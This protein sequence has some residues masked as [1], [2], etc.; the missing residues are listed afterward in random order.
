MPSRLQPVL[1]HALHLCAP[2]PQ[3]DRRGSPYACAAHAVRRRI[4]A[5]RDRRGTAYSQCCLGPLLTMTCS[6]QP[7]IENHVGRFASRSSSSF[8]QSRMSSIMPRATCLMSCS[9]AST[10]CKSTCRGTEALV[11]AHRSPSTGNLFGFSCSYESTCDTRA[12]PSS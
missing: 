3:G 11:R 8:S 12:S 1:H 7:K 2:F 6:S 4:A 5:R 9:C 10:S